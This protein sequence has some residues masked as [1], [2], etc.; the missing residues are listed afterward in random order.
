MGDKTEELILFIVSDSFILVT[1]VALRQGLIGWPQT[2]FVAEDDL[3]LLLLYRPS[4][5]IKG[6]TIPD[7][8]KNFNTRHVSTCV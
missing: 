8:F 3:E 5:W 7:L 2:T 4:A 1:I 6:T